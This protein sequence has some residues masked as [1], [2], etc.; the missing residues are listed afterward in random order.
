VQNPDIHTFS[1][2]I[3]RLKIKRLASTSGHSPQFLYQAEKPRTIEKKKK[4][5]GSLKLKLNPKVQCEQ[6]KNANRN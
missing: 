2:K 5:N 6:G 1:T 3:H 4:K